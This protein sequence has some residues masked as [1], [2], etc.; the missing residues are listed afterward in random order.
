MRW[1]LSE[2]QSG[3]F[4]SLGQREASKWAMAAFS[5]VNWRARTSDIAISYACHRTRL[6]LLS[7]V[8]KCDIIPLLARTSS[9]IRSTGDVRLKIGDQA[10]LFPIA[11]AGRIEAAAATGFLALLRRLAVAFGAAGGGFGERALGGR[12][13]G[14]PLCGGG[15]HRPLLGV[16]GGRPP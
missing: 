3:Q 10:V 2:P 13:Q 14:A 15:W 6:G 4:T 16:A 5:S 7:Q 1:T 11:V 12:R 9:R 8:Y